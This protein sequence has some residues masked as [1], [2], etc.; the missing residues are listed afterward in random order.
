MAVV[1]DYMRLI[2]VAVA[3]EVESFDNS[4]DNGARLVDQ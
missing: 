3:D 4:T 1:F 2:K